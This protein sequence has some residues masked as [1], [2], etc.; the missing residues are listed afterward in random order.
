DRSDAIYVNGA[1]QPWVI[2][3]DALVAVD[4]NISIEA[5]IAGTPTINLLNDFGLI[6][7]PSFDAD[8]GVLEVGP[9]ELAATL[10]NLLSDTHFRN[11]LIEKGKRNLSYYN[12]GVD[13]HATVRVANLMGQLMRPA[14][15]A[16][17]PVWQKYL[18]VSD[19]DA[20]GYHAHA[21]SELFEQALHTPRVLLDIGCGAGAT[22][23]WAKKNY[24]GLVAYGIELNQAAAGIAAQV[25]DK[26]WSSKFEEV[27]FEKDGIQKGSIDT[28]VVADVLEH[29]YNP[30][31][32][33]VQLKP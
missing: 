2:A 26:V 31:D 1:P 33:M 28:V 23:A 19:I 17:K 22:G 10:D 3:A 8:S 20:T 32:V 16:E 9:E 12:E 18:D 4:S 27:D 30:W 5:L 13:G 25:L 11:D 21:R 6:I 14:E 24:P 7:G 15:A 29:M